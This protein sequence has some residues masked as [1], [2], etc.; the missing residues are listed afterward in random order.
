MRRRDE[1]V[2]C[3]QRECLDV[4]RAGPSAELAQQSRRAVVG[5]EGLRR[6][7]DGHRLR[8]ALHQLHHIDAEHLGYRDE[9]VE[10]GIAST[11]LKRR[12][13]GG[14]SPDRWASS[15]PERPRSVRYRRT[16]RPIEADKAST[17]FIVC[18]DPLTGPSR[19]RGP[20]RPAIRS[21]RRDGAWRPRGIDTDGV[22]LSSNFCTDMRDDRRLV[23]PHGR[24]RGEA[25]IRLNQV[26]TSLS[27]T[28][29]HYNDRRNIFCYHVGIVANVERVV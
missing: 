13:R 26:A 19:P 4:N 18:L 27:V 25:E 7:L 24:C 1:A 28:G 17:A 16:V 11:G 22:R 12:Q 14:R 9:R 20:A 10:G 3:R 8:P 15:N 6:P 5:G 21:R 2:A 29:V 23:A